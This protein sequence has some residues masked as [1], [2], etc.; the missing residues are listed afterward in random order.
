M[1]AVAVKGKRRQG[2]SG[3][4]GNS[5]QGDNSTIQ[6]SEFLRS[7]SE[8]D[9]GKGLDSYSS[10]FSIHVSVLVTISI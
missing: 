8:E 2:A 6:S 4:R 3:S 7:A 10:H 1:E 5:R 9:H